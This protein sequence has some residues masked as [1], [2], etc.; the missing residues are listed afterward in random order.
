MRWIWMRCMKAKI[1][2]KML[3]WFLSRFF[4][5]PFKVCAALGT[6]LEIV[7]NRQK[8]IVVVQWPA[9]TN[10][11][12]PQFYMCS[13][14][15][16]KR[17]LET[18]KSEAWNTQKAISDVI[19][20][21]R[22]FTVVSVLATATTITGNDLTQCVRVQRFRQMLDFFVETHICGNCYAH[23]NWPTTHK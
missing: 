12:M 7:R 2:C 23:R 16:E 18:E 14:D 1:L 5:F 17:K 13:S 6:C 21:Q 20:V 9:S 3:S 8:C 11:T 4:V 10:F 19:F 22:H 15:E